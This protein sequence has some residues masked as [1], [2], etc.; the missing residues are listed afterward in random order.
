MTLCTS[1]SLC[2]CFIVAGCHN[3]FR[4]SL[5][6]AGSSLRSCRHLLGGMRCK[7][8]LATAG[9]CQ[10]HWCERPTMLKCC[11]FKKTF[12]KPLF[13][14]I[15]G[16]KIRGATFVEKFQSS[17]WFVVGI[18]AHTLITT[19]KAAMQSNYS[20][21][22]A[23]ESNICKYV[24][25]S[26]IKKNKIKR[27][28][29]SSYPETVLVHVVWQMAELNSHN[30]HASEPVWVKTTNKVS[31]HC[32]T[33]VGFCRLP[34]KKHKLN[35]RRIE[36]KYVLASGITMRLTSYFH[37]HTPRILIIFSCHQRSQ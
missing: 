16:W 17:V 27:K 2:S 36:N 37:M 30:I 19:C 22:K 13:L 23:S 35:W 26:N 18:A 28:S 25:W 34:K 3:E 11:I 33:H 7:F 4:V 12:Q 14:H 21:T 31:S 8:L 15:S 6:N 24:Q 5:H 32:V 9:E 20:S 1:E 29:E 10:T